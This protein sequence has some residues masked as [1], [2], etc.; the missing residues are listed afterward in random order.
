MQL[1]LDN[2]E[3]WDIVAQ[4]QHYIYEAFNEAELNGGDYPADAMQHQYTTMLERIVFEMTS[5]PVNRESADLDPI[6]DP[7]DVQDAYDQI[8]E[9]VGTAFGHTYSKIEKDMHTILDMYTVD[10]LRVIY[11]LKKSNR[12]H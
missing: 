9:M 10:D 7:L 2:T 3:V 8:L 6:D 5:L 12:L 11:E 1:Q 4:V